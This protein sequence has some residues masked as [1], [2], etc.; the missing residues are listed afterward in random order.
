MIEVDFFVDLERTVWDALV[1]GDAEADAAVLAH[2]FVGVYPTGF[3]DAG[4]HAGQ[5]ANGPTVAEFTIADPR[6]LQVADGHVMLSYLATYRRPGRDAVEQMYVS[7]LWS[8]VE[9]RWVNVFS[10]DTPVGGSVV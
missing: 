9:R 1:A 7:S 5:L 8:M 3:A 4:D 2:N 10:Q 6:V